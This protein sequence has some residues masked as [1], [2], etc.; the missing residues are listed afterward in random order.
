[1][2]L[3]E[4]KDLFLFELS[5]IYTGEKAI[6][7]ML[8]DVAGDVDNDNLAKML[9]A[10]QRETKDQAKMLES[11]FQHLGESPM[12]VPC[13]VID[14]LRA[15]YREF[16]SQ[17][18]SPQVLTMF[19]LGGALKVEHFEI[20]TYRGLVDKAMMMGDTELAQNLKTILNQEEETAGKLERFANELDHKVL[21][22]A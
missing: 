18:P 22:P 12:D 5:A 7:E 14:A 4:P 16:V 9:K 17:K 8:K 3:K 1:M 2:R 19:A 21:V 10:H 20:A 6:A 13:G 11:C 15:E